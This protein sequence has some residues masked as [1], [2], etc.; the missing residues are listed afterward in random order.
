MTTLDAVSLFLWPI[1]TVAAALFAVL[2]ISFAVDDTPWERAG[3]SRGYFLLGGLCSAG[4]AV[5]LGWTFFHVVIEAG[6]VG[7]R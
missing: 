2:L 5:I 1:G 4:I 6:R 3:L 7:G